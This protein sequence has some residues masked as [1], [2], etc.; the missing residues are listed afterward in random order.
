[1][2]QKR[3]EIAVIGAGVV[4][5]ACAFRLA[6]EGHDVLLLDQGEPG[7]GCSY[8]NAGHIA[9]E[10]I[11]PLASPA[12]LKA[13][14]GY[15]LRRNSP[16]SI[17]PSYLPKI[18]PWLARFAWHS[19]PSAYKRGTEALAALQRQAI[20]ALKALLTDAGAADLLHLKGHLMLVE[21]PEDQESMHRE[22]RQLA[23]H[24]VETRW[25]EGDELKQ[26][27]PGLGVDCQTAVYYPHSGHVSDPY[28][29][30]Q[31]LFQAF[32]EAGGRFLQT[33]VFNIEP[34]RSGFRLVS[35]NGAIT[36]DKLLI[37][38]GAWSAPLARCLGH[39]VP[40]ECERGY[41]LTANGSHAG[42]D[43]PVASMQHK[44]IMTPMQMGL[45]ITGTV[46]FGGLKAPPTQAR[47]ELLK[48]TLATLVPG[49]SQQDASYW[50]GHRPSLP[51]HLPV[52]SR[53][54]KHH[55]TYFA[56]GHQH[57]GLTLSAITADLI[58]QLQRKPVMSAPQPFRL[59]RF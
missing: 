39:N 27:A 44:V 45:R 51:D 9:T 53:C 16:L 59:N 17:K 33:R 35:E 6:K 38:A 32:T 3:A 10:Q 36:S 41:H 31:R 55:N 46:E 14:P 48:R 5:L 21:R 26:R 57:L 43:I 49:V 2:S 4:G 50:M 23:E 13:A 47:F 8:G 25:V 58:Y 24:G 52:I 19:R 56:F 11:F 29:V 37:S 22:C 30:S 7:R 54:P 15:L 20:P 40:L 42:F 18:A 1:M 28:A 34:Q 12:T